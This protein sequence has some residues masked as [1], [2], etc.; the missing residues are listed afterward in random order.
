MAL[1]ATSDIYWIA[2]GRPKDADLSALAPHFAKIRKAYLIGEAADAFA[3]SLAGS[4]EVMHCGE[5]NKAVAASFADARAAG[6]GTV[7]FSPAALSFDQYA[8]FE[9]RGDAFKAAVHTFAGG[10]AA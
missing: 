5:L 4:V 8:D 1:A 3:A 10:E 6:G 7:L 9:A 2:G